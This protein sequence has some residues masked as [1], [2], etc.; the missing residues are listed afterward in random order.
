MNRRSIFHGLASAIVS[1]QLVAASDQLHSPPK[2]V[3]HAG[4]QSSNSSMTHNRFMGIARH[5]YK[6]AAGVFPDSEGM[7][8]AIAALVLH[9]S[10]H[11][12]AKRKP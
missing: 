11:K 8:N 9:A 4:K 10:T 1:P 6:E 12:E 2:I 3:N 5:A 7:E